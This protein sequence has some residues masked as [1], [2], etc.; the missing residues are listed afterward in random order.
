MI[1]R[2]VAAHCQRSCSKLERKALG[3]YLTVLAEGGVFVKGKRAKPVIMFGVDS[4]ITHG[5][6]RCRSRVC[7]TDVMYSSNLRVDRQVHRQQDEYGRVK[8]NF[9]TRSAI[10]RIEIS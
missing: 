7:Q 9:D 2:A 3:I 6:I 4:L 10:Q 5:T 8:I 1:V